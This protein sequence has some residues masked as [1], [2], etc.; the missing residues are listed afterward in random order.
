MFAEY[1]RVV[2]TRQSPANNVTFA[3]TNSRRNTADHLPP[4]SGAGGGGGSEFSAVFHI[5]DPGSVAITRG[6]D[7]FLS[8]AGNLFGPQNQCN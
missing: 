5:W 1:H 8:P 6:F 4:S 2:A 3:I 7:T